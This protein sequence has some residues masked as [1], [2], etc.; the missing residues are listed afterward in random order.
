MR[1]DSH[2]TS[3]MDDQSDILN[4]SSDDDN[5]IFDSI[6]ADIE[7]AEST[8]DSINA[9]KYSLRRKIEERLELKHFKEEFG[10]LSDF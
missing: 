8:K 7:V 9:M 4:L 1:S 5:D 10:D 6:D 3:D 2:L